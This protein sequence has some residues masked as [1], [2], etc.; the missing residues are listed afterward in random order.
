MT[1]KQATFLKAPL[2]IYISQYEH[3]VDNEAVTDFAASNKDI[4]VYFLKSTHFF[5]K[6]EFV[7]DVLYTPFKQLL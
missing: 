6:S 3:L 7:I 2:H 4:S 5:G 1:R